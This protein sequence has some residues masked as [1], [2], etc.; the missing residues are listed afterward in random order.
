LGQ[1]FFDEYKKEAVEKFMSEFEELDLPDVNRKDK[2]GKIDVATSIW[3]IDF[4]NITFDPVN[5]DIQLSQAKP[6]FNIKFVNVGM[7]LA[8]DYSIDTTPT[9]VNEMGTGSG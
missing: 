9:L 1:T 6:Q 8:F 3:D 5:T 2:F 4:F 7:N